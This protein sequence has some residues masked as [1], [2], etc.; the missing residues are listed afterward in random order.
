[1]F[2][3]TAIQVWRLATHVF[4]ADA[5]GFRLLFQ[6]VWVLTYG[7]T[8]ESSTYSALPEDYLFLFIFA[9][10]CFTLMSLILGPLLGLGYILFTGSSMVMTLLYV[11]SKEFSQQV[12]KACKNCFCHSVAT[13]L[14]CKC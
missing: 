6:C 13:T 1:M 14:E 3:P 7:S 2:T 11:W 10:G 12:L 4:F 8:L 5:L 9:T